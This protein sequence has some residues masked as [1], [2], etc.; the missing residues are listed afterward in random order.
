VL[1]NERAM[2]ESETHYFP[3]IP[4][5]ADFMFQIGTAASQAVVDR[6]R[7]PRPGGPCSVG[8]WRP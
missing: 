7:R 6:R 3:Y 5:L 1:L 4:E 2:L 8:R